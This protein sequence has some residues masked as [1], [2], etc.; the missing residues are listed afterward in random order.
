MKI[1]LLSALLVAVIAI[2]A[3]LSLGVAGFSSEAKNTGP[4]VRLDK[5]SK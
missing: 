3:N 5:P 4:S 2:G 1:I